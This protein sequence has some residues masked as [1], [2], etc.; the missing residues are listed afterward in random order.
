MKPNQ[1]SKSPFS[2][3]KPV[4]FGFALQR[5]APDGRVEI[6]MRWGRLLAAFSALGVALW[7]T[8]TAG[9]YILYKYKKEYDAISYTDVLLFPVKRAEIREKMGNYHVK[10][11]IQLLN[12]GE[13]RDGLRLIRL[14]VA[15]APSNLEGRLIVA[16]LFESA[17]KRPDRAADM[18]L[19][20]LEYGGI[21]DTPY[22]KQTLQLLL[23]HQMDSAIQDLADQHLPPEP[24]LSDRNRLLAFGAA[25]A[26]Y[27]RGNYDRAD[28]YIL[29]YNMTD[30]REG[31]LLSAQI[32]WDRGNKV[33]AITKMEQSLNKF[34]G[35]EALLMQLSRYNRELGKIEEAR[36]YA[37]LRNVAAP[38]SSAPRIELL[39]IYN[40]TGDNDREKRET[41]NM[42][43]QFRDDEQALQAL[44]NFGADTGNIELT[45]RTYEEALENEFDI[46]SFA[47][48]LIEAHLVSKDYNGALDFAEELI[49]ENPEWLT[50]R[51]AIF[52]SL[53][54]VASYGINRPDEGQIYLQD[55][56][57]EVG[58]PPQTYLAVAR[59]F[60]MIDRAPQARKILSAAYQLAP[61]NQK[62]LS[63]LIR[64]ELELGY[65]ED[66]NRLLTRFLQMRRPQ[67]D[68]LVEAYRK[69]GSDRFIFT[70]D[71]ESLLLE[72]SALL[73]ENAQ[74]SDLM[75]EQS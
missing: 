21:D 42:L 33:A 25:N 37:I 9:L 66:L 48:L 13:V 59:R 6:S 75:N 11:G 12:E 29:S 61:S 64:V 34:P 3:E 70:P 47:L 57:N 68:L 73:R 10:T 72:L 20:G 55:F 41:K 23:R 46:D 26:N 52:Q 4:L 67:V 28:D 51:R 71:R 32:S 7:L 35:S 74:T 36:Q 60:S 54:A 14:G 53:R 50:K 69:L 24:E 16:A 1:N 27:L 58:T 31:V 49:K 40:K 2:R 22:L 38:L 44:A 30:T 15:R 8:L 18:L 43:K 45:R 39:Y 62:I 17:L 63:E 56:V 5:K 19:Q 65:T